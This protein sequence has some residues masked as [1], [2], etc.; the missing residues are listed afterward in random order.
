MGQQQLRRWALLRLGRRQVTNQLFRE[1][2]EGLIP[3]PRKRTGGRTR[4]VFIPPGRTIWHAD[5]PT[6]AELNAGVDISHV[7]TIA[8]WDSW[9]K[10]HPVWPNEPEL[11]PRARALAAKQSRNTGPAATPLRVRGRNTHYKEK[12]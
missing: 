11:D 7:V 5:A 4:I 10:D 6:V 12:S 9:A 2:L 1:V 3:F 8:G